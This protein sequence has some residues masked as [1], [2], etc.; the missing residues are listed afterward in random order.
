MDEVHLSNGIISFPC[1]YLALAWYCAVRIGTRTGL[2][3]SFPTPLTLSLH[4]WNNV[5]TRV[6]RAIKTATGQTRERRLCLTNLRTE[7]YCRLL[8]QGLCHMQIVIDVITTMRYQLISAIRIQLKETA[9]IVTNHPDT[10]RETPFPPRH[11]YSTEGVANSSVMFR[12][13]A[14]ST[15][16]LLR[17]PKEAPIIG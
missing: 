1:V 14:S 15:G 3:L 4:K 12:S 9:G 8:H 5:L 7:V 16:R 10:I 17:L 2:L 13:S 11:T 6:K